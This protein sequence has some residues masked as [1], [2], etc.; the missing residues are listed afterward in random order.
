METIKNVNI[1]TSPIINFQLPPMI[2]GDRRTEGDSQDRSG[3]V[4]AYVFE[5][6]E[7]LAK[8]EGS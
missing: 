4:C 5:Y 6:L 7:R 3:I 8:K 1:T 2:V